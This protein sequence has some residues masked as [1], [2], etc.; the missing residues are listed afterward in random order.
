MT[1]IQVDWYTGADWCDWY[2]GGLVYLIHWY[3]GGLVYWYFMK[4]FSFVINSNFVYIFIII[5]QFLFILC[6]YDFS[7]FIEAPLLSI[8]FITLSL[9]NFVYQRSRFCFLCLYLVTPMPPWR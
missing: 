9:F 8:L 7:L 3:T 4:H 5:V 2:T 1:G 6:R